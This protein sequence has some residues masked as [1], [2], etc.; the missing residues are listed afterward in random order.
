M[1]FPQA[2]LYC[3]VRDVPRLEIPKASWEFKQKLKKNV[4]VLHDFMMSSEGMGTHTYTY[5]HTDVSGRCVWYHNVPYVGYGPVSS[6]YIITSYPNRRFSS[7][8]FL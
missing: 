7:D 3:G 4:E 5:T 2:H 6:A 1:P 8:E